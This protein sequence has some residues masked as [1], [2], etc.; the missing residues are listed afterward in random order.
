MPAHHC[1]TVRPSG[2]SRRRT[3]SQWRYRPSFK[4]APTLTNRTN[5]SGS[6]SLIRAYR[7]GGLA[8]PR[9]HSVSVTVCSDRKT[10]QI[11]LLINTRLVHKP[12][13]A[14]RLPWPLGG[15]DGLA[16]PLVAFRLLDVPLGVRLRRRALQ[17][18]PLPAHATPP[19]HGQTTG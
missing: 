17:G 2:G 3:S 7:S 6:R 12:G 5:V 1:S 19:F 15:P 4:V 11:H 9:S 18:T 13:L 10:G 8:I 16:T 14:R